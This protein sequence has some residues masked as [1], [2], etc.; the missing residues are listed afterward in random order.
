M[1]NYH[2]VYL[3]WPTASDTG[4][5]KSLFPDTVH[6]LPFC[7]PP[8]ANSLRH[9]NIESTFPRHCPTITF[10]VYL[11]WPTASESGISI[12]STF[13]RQCPYITFLVHLSRRELI[14]YP[15]SGVR[16]RCR[17]H[18]RSPFS[19]ILISKTY[20][21]NATKFYLKHHWG[22]GKAASGFGPNRIRTLV[23]M[24]TDSSH[25]VIMG[26]TASSRFLK[27][28]NWILVIFAGNDDMHMSLKDFE[29]QPYPTTDCY[30]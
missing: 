8:L 20:R 24:A 23:S 29:I 13:P 7:L 10:F 17:R 28:F 25:R 5:S 18:R 9:Q 21:P 15:C 6:T 26:K 22:E 16:R 11:R 3:R 30:L 1:I 27:V 19:N 14:V 12:E 4:I 2:F